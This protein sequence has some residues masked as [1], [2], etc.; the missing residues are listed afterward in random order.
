MSSSTRISSVATWGN[1]RLPNQIDTPNPTNSVDSVDSVD[2]NNTKSS[3]THATESD[4]VWEHNAWDMVTPPPSHVH[5]ISQ[6][7][8]KHRDSPVS[9]DRRN[10]VLE[11]AGGMWDQFYCNNENRFFKHRQWLKIE[12]PELFN[13]TEK[14]IWEVGCGVGNT[15]FPLANEVHGTFIYACDFSKTAIDI[16]LS[17]PEYDEKRMCAFVYDLTDLKVPSEIEPE[18][19]DV[20]TC[21]FCLSAIPPSHHSHVVSTFYKLLKKGGILLFRDYGRGDLTQ[22]RF[23]KER[24]LDEDWYIRGDGTQVYFFTQDILASLFQQGW[25]KISMALDTRMLVNRK[26]RKKMFRVWIQA[27]FRKI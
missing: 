11:H 16:V 12:F 9:K 17:T 7:I 19:L 6:Q 22:I 13:Q 2:S 20:I 14:R 10:L 21:I 15:V 5:Y 24:Y 25:D 4:V 27:K 3:E 1:R 23:K 8:S 18:S 26:E